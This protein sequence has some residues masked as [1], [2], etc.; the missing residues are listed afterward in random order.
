MVKSRNRSRTWS[1]TIQDDT[2]RGASRAPAGEVRTWA[3]LRAMAVAHDIDQNA[4][5]GLGLAEMITALGPAPMT[6]LCPQRYLA[7]AVSGQLRPRAGHIQMTGACPL[8][9]RQHERPGTAAV[10]HP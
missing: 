3:E 5:S 8:C 1:V 9:A 6:D 4:V 2:E 10:T 7:M